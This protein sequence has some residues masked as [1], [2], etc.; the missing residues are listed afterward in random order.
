MMKNLEHANLLVKAEILVGSTEAANELGISLTSALN[1]V[2]I[3]LKSFNSTSDFISYLQASQF[4]E[5]VAKDNCCPYFGFLVGKYQPPLRLGLVGQLF[6]LSPNLYAA[7]KLASDY[8]KLYSQA[9]ETE[10]II[11]NGFVH[12]IRRDREFI[13][14]RMEL[15]HGRGV[16]ITGHQACNTMKFPLHILVWVSA[17]KCIKLLTIPLLGK[18]E[19]SDNNIP[20]RLG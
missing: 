18:A 13:Q 7:I 3:P 19:K 4:L 8:I 5:T 20:F 16:L 10:L 12:M 9:V 2:N 14:K 17:R 1:Q 11:D 15:F 6:K